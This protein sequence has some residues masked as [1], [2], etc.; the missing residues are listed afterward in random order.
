MFKYI[1]L[2][3]SNLNLVFVERCDKLILFYKTFIKINKSLNGKIVFYIL[4]QVRTKQMF[5]CFTLFFL[6]L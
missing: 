2:K 5:V 1:F 4:P 3:K 6:F